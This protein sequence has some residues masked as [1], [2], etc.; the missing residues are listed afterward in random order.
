[1]LQLVNYKALTD[2]HISVLV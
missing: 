2:R 1:L